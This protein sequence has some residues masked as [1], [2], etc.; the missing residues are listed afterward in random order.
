MVYKR[1][2]YILLCILFI[3]F[4]LSLR[5]LGFFSES[6]IYT[7]HLCI[8]FIL[9]FSWLILFNHRLF[10]MT[11]K[12]LS[13]MIKYVGQDC[14]LLYKIH[15]RNGVID[16]IYVKLNDSTYPN[17]Y[18]LDYILSGIDKDCGMNVYNTFRIYNSSVGDLL[19]TMCH[20]SED[21]LIGE[22][23]KQYKSDYN[24]YRWLSL[25]ML[26]G[27]VYLVYIV[28]LMNFVYSAEEIEEL[29]CILGI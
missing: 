19:H 12:R 23:Y 25:F 15:E 3:V 7:D 21:V 6:Y 4:Y 16:G 18:E 11:R 5:I 26:Y 28:I 14:E 17:W 20:N 13:N 27:M 22:R 2:Q 9:F 1:D 24:C 29:F 10:V 8:F